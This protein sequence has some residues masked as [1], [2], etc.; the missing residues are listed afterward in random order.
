MRN[1]TQAGKKPVRVTAKDNKISIK[2]PSD[3]RGKAKAPQVSKKPRS[4]PSS[5][6]E[7]DSD[8]EDE[9]EDRS[10]M[11]A[12]LE[13]Q[14]RAMLGLEPISRGESSTALKGKKRA[15]ELS[16]ENEIEDEDDQEEEI[17][18]DGW[19]AEDD[20][21]TDSEDEFAD[22]SLNV[23]L[24]SIHQVPEVV[25]DGTSGAKRDM[26]MT[27]AERKAFMNGNSA[28]MMGLKRDDDYEVRPS[29][30]ARA[31]SE[32]L[33][34]QS[35]LKLDQT[36][37]KMIVNT[38]ISE[39]TLENSS[40]PVDKRNYLQ[41]R[42]NELASYNIPGQGQSTI[43]SAALSKLPAHIRTGIIHKQAKRE[44]I[45]K[46]SERAAGNI[47]QRFGGLSDGLN[48]RGSK[49]E[50]RAEV[51][52]DVSKKKGMS[53]RVKDDSSRSRGLSMG[54]GRFSNG[55]LKLSKGEIDSV[56]NS[57]SALSGRGG[58][59]GGRGGR[60]GKRR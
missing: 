31:G 43:K 27:K 26:G 19:G 20:F 2:T 13:A 37:H 12:A 52:M 38:L 4:T 35:N 6:S 42:L 34:E 53:G 39:N 51:G 30:K 24:Q 41:G 8:N 44:K 5:S 15:I 48:K 10:T 1:A 59:R 46:E 11:L 32:D 29:K 47:D 9:D 17:S 3:S 28:K 55:M 14:S 56:N 45:S 57:R 49:G 54:V 50:Q 7:A 40:R 60:G 23:P 22:P 36:L 16:D 33:E 21:I 58:K 18:D 25:F